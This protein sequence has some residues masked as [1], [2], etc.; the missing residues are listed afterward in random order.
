MEWDHRGIRRSAATALLVVLLAALPLPAA[1]A[2]TRPG[3]VAGTLLDVAANPL[4]GIEVRVYETSTAWN[5]VATTSTAS[6]GTYLVDALPPGEYKV[7]FGSQSDGFVTRWH[8]AQ[9]S[10]TTAAA[11]NVSHGT[12][13]RGI[14][15]VLQ[16][17]GAITGLVTGGGAFL[18]NIAVSVYTTAG[19]F[20]TSTTTSGGGTYTASG[21]ASG[22]YLVKFSDP[23]GAYAFEWYDNQTSQDAADPVEVTAPAIT[24][25][26]DADLVAAASISGT[27][28][29][30]GGTLLPGIRVE[31]RDLANTLVGS[32]D[33]AGDGSYRIGGLPA[34]DFVIQFIDWSN[35]YVGEWYD[36]RGSFETATVITLAAGGSATAAAVLEATPPGGTIAGRVT[37]LTGTPLAGLAV[38]LLGSADLD[39]LIAFATTNAAGEYS[40]TSLDA[41][42]YYVAVIDDSGA[43]A[44]DVEFLALGSS[45]GRYL[46]SE[47]APGAAISGV[48]SDES[49]PLQGID[50]T[51]RVNP[52]QLAT[53]TDG[54]GRYAF[55][56]LPAGFFFP[57][58]ADPA[59]WHLPQTERVVL[60][61]GETRT[62]HVF[63]PLAARISG[64]VTDTTGTPLSGITVSG[65]S[66]I[67][68]LVSGTSGTLHDS[69]VLGHPWL[70]RTDAVG[71]FEV[72]VSAG[73]HGVG[74]AD[75]ADVYAPERYQDR[76]PCCDWRNA[77]LV[78][79]VAGEVLT[80][81]AVLDAPGV[82]TGTVTND[83]GDPLSDILVIA[84]FPDGISWAGDFVTGADGKYLIRGLAPG[85]YLLYFRDW[86]GSY[87]SE[88]YDNRPSPEL[89]DPVDVRAGEVTSGVN[90][91]LRPPPLP[92]SIAGTVSHGVAP[93]VSANVAAYNATGRAVGSA[94]TDAGGRYSV[95]VEP[96]IYKLRV[97]PGAP[98]AVE[99]YDNRTSFEEATPVD[100]RLA[101]ASNVDFAVDEAGTVAGS[102]T[103]AAGQPLLAIVDLIGADGFP[104]ASTVTESTGGTYSAVATPGEYTVRFAAAGYTPQ[105]YDKVTDQAA[106]TPVSVTAGG[107]IAGIDAAL[108]PAGGISGSVTD[109]IGTA[110]PGVVVLLSHAGDGLRGAVA[111][112]QLGN[113]Q[114]PLGETGAFEVEFRHPDYP[115]EWYDDQS[116][117]SSATIV[118]TSPTTWTTGIDAVLG[119]L[120]VRLSGLDRFATA[121]AISQHAF[122]RGAPVVYVA[123]GLNFPD[124]LAG[125]PAAALAGGP[126]LLVTRDVLPAATATELTR[127]DPA[128]IVILGGTGAVSSAVETALGPYAPVV[129]R[130]W[131]P[132]RFATAAAISQD[133]F[134][135]GAPVAY[136]ANG[137]N[138]P[139]ALAG[140]PAAALARGPLLLVTKDL[141]PQATADELARLGPSRVVIL[142]GSG[143]V[144]D[145]VASQLIQL[146]PS[147]TLSRLWGADRFAT[148]A[149]ISRDTFP[150]GAPV[151][152]VA[153]GLNFPDAL[154][155]GPAAALAGGP[156]LLVTKDAVPQ[157]TATE[158]T[159]LG[160][161][162]VF[163]L[164]GPGAISEA[165]ADALRALAQP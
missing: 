147:A 118:N 158:L 42:T 136:I 6:D 144:S 46:R 75:P 100:V 45:V 40:F 28:T 10:F 44:M 14:D 151:A 140:G 63:M 162:Q 9:Q 77:D 71:H 82:V 54:A 137:L 58:V 106:A 67:T 18:G 16:A 43:Y 48:V 47:L 5:P 13:T 30:T 19:S 78:G 161:S 33:T 105:W 98:L 132:D 37:D 76:P 152:F 90:A 27:V 156:L 109:P 102:V 130:L 141:I 55:V 104:A 21:L 131:G 12:V 38:R 157:A 108:A 93:V 70:V 56:G 126:L 149:A 84:F 15:A 159:R 123:N 17:A 111:T 72:T 120:T 110:L 36:D 134:P 154:A 148:A 49:G 1:H 2:Q 103:D 50:V 164:G 87:A 88:W 95:S 79:A 32:A 26:I 145:L 89:A 96:G 80:I 29:N 163:I 99:W 92:T 22:F 66:W 155:G 41:G 122:P 165:V 121:T 101:P 107:S 94:W 68:A 57:A 35:S 74:F 23:A 117:A 138:F 39:D 113:Y 153:N 61:T 51:I 34:G 115:T 97:S 83:G 135:A 62:L 86:S 69:H 7:A 20:V 60:A 73:A 119:S 129:R 81:N 127:L 139:D 85:S 114:A 125:G 133:T 52:L 142:G 3:G 160:P 8:P 116:S 11:V 53:S 112:D 24:S 146:L 25:N 150:T 31:A 91:R 128:E 124:A 64:Q 143:V 4:A 59:G 65:T